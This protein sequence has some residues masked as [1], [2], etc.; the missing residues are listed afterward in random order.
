VKAEKTLDCV[1]MKAEIQERL[2]G[3]VAEL[4]EDA[5]PHPQ[6]EQCSLTKS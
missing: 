2:L 3:E 6:G 4:G 1:E 5:A